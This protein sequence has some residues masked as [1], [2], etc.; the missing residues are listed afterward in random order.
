MKKITRKDF[1]KTNALALASAF[2]PKTLLGQIME[3]ESDRDEPLIIRL[4]KGND[5]SVENYLNLMNRAQQRQ[6]YRYLSSPFAAFTAAYCHPES[7]YFKSKKLL[8]ALEQTIE[9][10]RTVQYP[11][12]TLDSG[13][14]RQS[15]PDTGFVLEALC[16]AANI[17]N[18]QDFPELSNVKSELERF[19]LR[20]GEGIRT[21]GVHTPNHRWVV[22]SVLAQLYALFKDD[23]YVARIEEWLAEGIFINEDGQYPERSRNYSIVENNSLINIAQILDR[24]ELYDIVKKNLVSTYYYMESDGELVCLDS[25]R[26]DQYRQVSI[27]RFYLHYRYMAIHE[28]DSFLAAV[29]RRI[30]SF[31]DF[32][33]VVL[34]RSLPAFMT[35]ALLGRELPEN[36]KLPDRYTKHFVKSDLVRIKNGD[37]S[38]SIYGGTDKPLVI[39]SGRSCIPTFFTFRK[40]SAVL[41]YARLSTSFFRTGYFRSDGLIKDGNRYILSEKKEAYYYHPLPE[42]ERNDGGDYEL[43]ESLD[44]RF[45]S[46]MAFGSRPK[47]TLTLDMSIVIEEENRSFR[48]DLDINGT[49]NVAVTLELCFRKGGTLEGVTEGDNQDDYFL[50]EGYATYTSGN[51]SIQVG[52][53]HFTHANLRGLDGEVYSTHF[54]SIKGE[55]KHL[56]ITGLVPFK[57]SITIA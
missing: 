32:D 1:L 5:R 48:M 39:A 13:G 10:L 19:L 17:L 40:G 18:K 53:G 38:A 44:G 29:A 25:R 2:A 52:P 9:K 35:S 4:V 3:Q 8:L 54:G 7:S 43:T 49:E 55:G 26:Q 30:E 24:P 12:G 15:P 50:E 16:P 23:K 42:T 14:N 31:D 22:C 28:N 27:T 21:G 34:S 46:K 41:E 57:H 37:V 20:A 56:Y 47:N 36:T 6:Y 51:D 45:W 33:R 11:D